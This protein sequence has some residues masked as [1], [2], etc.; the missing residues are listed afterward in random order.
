MV[1]V[2]QILD[3]W[4]AGQ[5]LVLGLALGFPLLKAGVPVERVVPN[6]AALSRQPMTALPPPPAWASGPQTA[7]WTVDNVAAEFRKVTATPPQIVHGALAFVRP[8]HRWLL[9]YVRWF[10]LLG[11]PLNL[12]YQDELFNCVNYSRCFVVFADL[13]AQNGGEGRGSI[14]VGWATVFNRNSFAGVPAGGAHAI[15]I[16]GTSEG[17]F[18]VEPQ[19]GTMVAL[20]DYPN[21]DELAEMNL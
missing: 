3:S 6:V 21:R 13:L 10:R 16:A 18:V 15:V 7:L 8:D 14:C 12:H 11:K 19:T 5:I 2:S 4:R 20:R 17:L 9:A 1:C